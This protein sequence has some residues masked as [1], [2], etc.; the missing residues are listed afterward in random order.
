MKKYITVLLVLSILLISNS[1]FSQKS[2]TYFS[3]EQ[4]TFDQSKLITTNNINSLISVNQL[5]IGNQNQVILNQIGTY[6]V[7][8]VTQSQKTQQNISQIGRENYYGFIDYYNKTQINFNIL[9]EGNSN[10]LQIYG[11]NSIMNGM[12]IIQKSNFKSIVIKNYK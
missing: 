11:S 10:S 7:A 5:N 1:L 12:E 4:N 6:N 3:N 2:P 8:D 9:Q